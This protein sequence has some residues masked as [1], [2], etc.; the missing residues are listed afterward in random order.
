MEKLTG[1]DCKV[2]YICWNC[3]FPWLQSSAASCSKT[4]QV[5]III[6]LQLLATVSTDIAWN[7]TEGSEIIKFIIKDPTVV[8]SLY[9]G[10]EQICT[11]CSVCRLHTIL[12]ILC[13]LRSCW[14]SCTST[15]TT[16]GQVKW[17]MFC[18]L[19]VRLSWSFYW[20][21]ECSKAAISFSSSMSN[22]GPLF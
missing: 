4:A 10:Q 2:E 5:G 6:E 11:K 19:S 22:A 8:F 15:S 1:D 21:K 17:F 3:V 14:S 7:K 16:A 9:R 20:K 13:L 18:M 12:F